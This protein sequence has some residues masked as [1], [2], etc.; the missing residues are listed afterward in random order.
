MRLLGLFNALA[1]A[2]S[3]GLGLADLNAKLRSP[4]S[5]L[6]NLLR[7]LVATGYLNLEN[8]RYRLGPMLFQLSGLIMSGWNFSSAVR[9]YL[10]ELARRS[11]ESAYLGVLDEEQMLITYVDSIDSAHSI[12]YSVPVGGLRPL[13]STA[14]GRVVL[15]FT[16]RL[17][18][19]HYVET[20]TLEARTPQTIHSAQALRR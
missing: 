7:P 15:A 3:H 6:L 12:R 19:D 9:P 13:Y 1:L 4:K 11:G 2:P 5:S 8:G 17:K 16:D 14:A 18:Q 20:T 10:E